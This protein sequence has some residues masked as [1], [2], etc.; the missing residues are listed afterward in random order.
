MGNCCQQGEGKPANN[1]ADRLKRENEQQ[2][3]KLELEQSLK[4]MANG[5]HSCACMPTPAPRP[6]AATAF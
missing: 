1:H 5:R 3:E 4:N 2:Q 6:C